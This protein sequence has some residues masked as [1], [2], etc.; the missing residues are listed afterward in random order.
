MDRRAFLTTLAGAGAAAMLPAAAEAAP[1]WLKLGTTRVNGLAD[2]DRIHV[3][4]GWGKFRRVRL[5]VRGNNLF[6][7]RFVVEFGNG[8]RQELRVRAFIPQG[9]YTRAIDLNGGKRFIKHVTFF[10]GKIP[11]GQGPTRVDLFGRR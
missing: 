8:Q 6:M 2:V 3:G 7:Y 9:G 4:A 5:G 11:N 1:S 10:Y